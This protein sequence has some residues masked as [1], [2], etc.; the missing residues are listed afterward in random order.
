MQAIQTAAGNP[1]TVPRANTRTQAVRLVPPAGE[2]GL[3]GPRNWSKAGESRSLV[4]TS[5]S[6]ADG[7]VAATRLPS[8]AQT[9]GTTRLHGVIVVRNQLRDQ[10]PN[11]F[12]RCWVMSGRRCSVAAYDFIVVGA[13]SAGCA[14]AG[15]LAAESSS[16][17]LLIEAGGS[18]RRLAV[19]APLAGIRQFGTSLD[20]GYETDPEPGFADHRDRR[21]ATRSC[22]PRRGG[23]STA[24]RSGTA[25]G[26]KRSVARVMPSRRL[27]LVVGFGETATNHVVLHCNSHQLAVDSR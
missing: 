8:G 2:R 19:R 9:C 4:G 1:P 11:V 12:A 26:D 13:G 22:R 23:N 16:T 14:V 21:A 24:A 6:V 18:D 20:W 10:I 25:R 5:C 27:S 17:V 3:A 7:A 15:R